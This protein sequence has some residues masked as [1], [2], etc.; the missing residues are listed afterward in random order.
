MDCE[1]PPAW[2]AA[3]NTML[4]HPHIEKWTARRLATYSHYNDAYASKLL[5]YMCCAGL[6]ERVGVGLYEIKYGQLELE[7]EQTVTITRWKMKEDE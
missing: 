1:M 4:R 3:L 7:P 6:L 5:S 2:K